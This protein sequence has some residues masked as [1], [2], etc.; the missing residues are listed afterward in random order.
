MRASAILLADRDHNRLYVPKRSG[1]A[2]TRQARFEQPIENP[3]AA[4]IATDLPMLWATFPGWI[5]AAVLQRLYGCS[6]HHLSVAIRAIVW[7]GRARYR[8]IGDRCR[9][10]LTPYGVDP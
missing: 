10:A 9:K 4:Q 6:R 2:I 5:E 7:H 3:L 8:Y 1:P